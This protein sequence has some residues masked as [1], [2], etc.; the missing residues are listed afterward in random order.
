MA[1]TAGAKVAMPKGDG[2]CGRRYGEIG[3][4]TGAGIGAGTG[5][6]GIIIGIVRGEELGTP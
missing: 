6:A 3:V 2:W 1:G 4:G 5:A